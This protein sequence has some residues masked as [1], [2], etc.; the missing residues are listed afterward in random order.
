MTRLRQALMAVMI[1]LGVVS[2][3][4]FSSLSVSAV[5]PLNESCKQDPNNPICKTASQGEDLFGPNSIW[6]RVIN[7]MIF[8]VG[9]IAVLMIVI[10]GLRYTLSNGDA[11]GTKSAK[12][13]II[14]AI[15]GLV[16]SIMAYAIVNF[17]LAR[18]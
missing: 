6:T 7:T 10:G 12:D 2:W 4:V 13:T 18:I 14:Y 3:T 5:D 17:V 8:V 15:I 16:I 9:A 11:S 1:L